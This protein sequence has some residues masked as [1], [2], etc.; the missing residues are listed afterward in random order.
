MVRRRRCGEEYNVKQVFD[1]TIEITNSA[2][3][4]VNPLASIKLNGGLPTKKPSQTK[5]LFVYNPNHYDET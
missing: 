1:G 5:R 2:Q 4:M 3:Y